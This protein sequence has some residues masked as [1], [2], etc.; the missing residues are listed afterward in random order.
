MGR[1]TPTGSFSLFLC[2][3]YRDLV[4]SPVLTRNEAVDCRRLLGERHPFERITR[5]LPLEELIAGVCPAPDVVAT[6]VEDIVAGIAGDREHRMA[7]PV[8][9]EHDSDPQ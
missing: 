7:L 3:Q 8:L 9:V 5:R 2:S 1:G 6:I 4:S